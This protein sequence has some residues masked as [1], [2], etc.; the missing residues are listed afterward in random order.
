MRG[1]VGL[2]AGLG[3]DLV[4]ACARAFSFAG[5]SPIRAVFPDLPERD[6]AP[7]FGRCGA[8][9]EAVGAA[10]LASAAALV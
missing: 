4:L 10:L 1:C 2:S 6:G 9:A 8:R 5:D 7:D 3:F